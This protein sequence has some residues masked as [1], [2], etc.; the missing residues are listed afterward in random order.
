MKNKLIP[1]IISATMILSSGSTFAAA[2]FSD[3]PEKHWAFRA[4]SA[5]VDRGGISGYPDGTF[6]PG[7]TITIAEFLKINVGA[8]LGEAEPTNNHWASGYFDKAIDAGILL[9]DDFRQSDWNKAIT[10]QQM[11]VIIA[12]TLELTLKEDIKA[13]DRDA[14]ISKISDYNTICTACRDSVINVYNVGI[15]TGYPDGTFKGENTATRA[16]A[17]TML[18]RMLDKTQRVNNE[19][20]LL[21]D[22]V[23]NIDEHKWFV[24]PYYTID[25]DVAKYN[26]KITDTTDWPGYDNYHVKFEA[27]SFNVMAGVIDGKIVEGPAANATATGGSARFTTDPATF[28]YFLI[29][30]G[31]EFKNTSGSIYFDAVAIPNPFKQ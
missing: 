30:I 14:V 29:V 31:G 11:A 20:L 19:K 23:S 7:G 10:R 9:P 17:S 22:F 3:L 1:V 24:S 27:G 6:K 2:S 12:R 5:L 25:Y 15:I 28:D 8:T 18:V 13:P 16:E 21:K 4:V 26:I